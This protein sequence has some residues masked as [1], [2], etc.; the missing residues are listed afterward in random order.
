MKTL[1]IFTQPA[2][3]ACPPAKKL[4]DKLKDLDN[5]KV[6]QIDVSTQKGLS[7]AQK[8]AIT[9]TPTLLLLIGD[10]EAKRWVGAPDE[11]EI[12]KFLS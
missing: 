12:K 5:V 11:N 4:G 7:Q 3:P 6:E 2:C 1:K 9:A 10:V 8:H